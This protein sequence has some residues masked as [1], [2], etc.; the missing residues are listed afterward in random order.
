MPVSAGRI[1]SRSVIQAITQSA[2][3]LIRITEQDSSGWVSRGLVIAAAVTTAAAVGALALGQRWLAV[4][5]LLPLLY[6]LPC[7]AMM[8][9]CMKGRS[10]GRQAGTTQTSS[11][12]EALSLSVL[13]NRNDVQRR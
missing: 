9:M 11:R 4:V 6:A 10:H 8:F 7:A 2:G 5:D 13:S 3:F 12:N 1:E